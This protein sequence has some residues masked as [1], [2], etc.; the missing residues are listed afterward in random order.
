MSKIIKT[1]DEAKEQIYRALSLASDPVIQTLSPRGGNVLFEDTYG[2]INVTNDGVTIIKQIE[3]DDPVEDKIIELIKFAAL[4]TNT[5][6]GDGTTTATLLTKIIVTEGMR[7]LDNGMSRL[8]LKEHLEKMSK[9]LTTLLTQKKIEVTDNEQLEQVARI[10]SNNDDEIAKNVLEVIDSAG[11]DGLILIEAHHKPDTKVIVEPGF[12]LKQPLAFPDLVQNRGFSSV[13]ED[14]PVLITDKRLYYE[15]EAETILRTALEAGHKKLV[16]VAADFIGKTPNFFLANHAAGSIELILVKESDGDTLT[17]L[18]TYLGGSVVSEKSGSLVDNLSAN[19]FTIA[20]KV[21]ADRARS[22]FT[23]KQAENPAVVERI[24]NLRSEI[25]GTE[26]SEDL[27]K[28]LAALTNGTVTIKVGGHTPVETQERIFRYEDAV[29]ATRAA[30]KDGYVVGGGLTLLSLYNPHEWDPEVGP[31]VKKFCE[32]S[33]RQIA[34]N[35]GKHPDT[36]LEKLAELDTLIY[37]SEVYG[38][39]AKTDE[40]E[41]LLKAGV[42]DPYRVT[43]MV[44]QNSISVAIALLT[45]GYFI[46]N[47]N[48]ED[49]G[50]TENE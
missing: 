20:D 29:S 27:E 3:S 44:I 4:R 48:Q 32:A 26:D 9:Y 25:D 14:V 50:R 8:E 46:V 6:A 21:F 42:V 22:I 7:L 43:E 36:V 30:Q 28:R 2:N 49:N 39:N 13:L 11:Q 23:S 33:I 40:F 31:V 18:A 38:Y 12:L 35:S 19:Q 15:Q 47:D 1:Y 16:V 45:S 34:Q 37:D 10:S 24:Q 41:D 5:E 17:D